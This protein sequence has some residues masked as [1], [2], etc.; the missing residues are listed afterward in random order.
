MSCYRP[1]PHPLIPALKSS[2]VFGAPPAG[3]LIW[4][5]FLVPPF[6]FWKHTAGIC[7]ICV[8]MEA[9]GWVPI[10]CWVKERRNEVEGSCWGGGLVSIGHRWR[11]QSRWGSGS[12]ESDQ[13]HFMPPASVG[14]SSSSVGGCM[15][16]LEADLEKTTTTARRATHLSRP[17]QQETLPQCKLHTTSCA[18]CETV[19][20]APFLF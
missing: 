12:R 7:F 10:C 5:F 19:K 9:A 14:N 8:T 20:N 1:L 13:C 3:D 17:P 6:I 15:N 18:I 4:S 2:L 16:Q 11:Q